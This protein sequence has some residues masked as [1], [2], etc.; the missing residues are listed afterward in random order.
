MRKTWFENGDWNAICDECGF[1]FKAKDLKKRWDGA[2]VCS[3][4]FETRH[5]QELIRPISDQQKLP[6]TRPEGT[7]QF[8]D[9][10]IKSVVMLANQKSVVITDATISTAHFVLVIGNIQD[11]KGVLAGVTSG[12]GTA[13]ITASV[14]PAADWTIYYRI[15][16]L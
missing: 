6:W 4:D 1:K 15:V 16:G 13:T 2:M 11:S 12:A 8:I 10:K 9:S 5:P 14:A 3:R 7:D